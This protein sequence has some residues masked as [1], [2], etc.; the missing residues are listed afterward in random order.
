[1]TSVR[2]NKSLAALSAIDPAKLDAPMQRADT[3]DGS[4]TGRQSW[5]RANAQTGTSEPMLRSKSHSKSLE[6]VRDD[7][8]LVVHDAD[9]WSTRLGASA[10][11]SFGEPTAGLWAS[12]SSLTSLGKVAGASKF[13]V[14]SRERHGLAWRGAASDD[15][16]DDDEQ[17]DAYGARQHGRLA[18]HARR[19]SSLSVFHDEYEHDD[20]ADASASG[21]PRHP[22]LPSVMAAP[23]VTTPG[24]MSSEPA[25]PLFFSARRLAPLPVSPPTAT[26]PRAA[27]APIAPAV[28]AGE[29]NKD[30]SV[31]FDEARE[32]AVDEDALID[33]VVASAAPHDGFGLSAL[34]RAAFDFGWSAASREDG[35]G[36][37]KGDSIASVTPQHKGAVGAKV[38][39][40][41]VPQDDT[42]GEQA[43]SLKE[44]S[45]IMA[46]KFT[47]A[48]L[49]YGDDDDG[50]GD[51]ESGE[52]A[53][54]GDYVR[55]G[56]GREGQQ[57]ERKPSLREGEA[58]ALSGLPTS[59]ESL[60]NVAEWF[61]RSTLASFY[62][63][64]SGDNVQHAL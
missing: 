56:G 37:S 54:L 30:L 31:P 49:L 17:Q 46:S 12:S 63:S 64:R 57:H 41:A 51:D 48:P 59:S 53:G 8:V 21:V 27:A 1:M 29:L 62:R 2:R 58:I 18:K 25:S 11:S 22:H 60:D 24:D 19:Q 10:A 5:R 38:T 32:L 3:L 14:D 7:E 55:V 4:E 13:I 16:D 9:D 39:T 6:S 50:G 20:Q 33:S 28:P 42:L 26:S 47:I 43:T 34:V 52:V 15:D 45:D 61:D 23:T 36:K 35:E 44:R 40:V